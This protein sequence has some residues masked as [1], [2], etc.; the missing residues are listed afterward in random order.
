MKLNKQWIKE[1]GKQVNEDK[2]FKVI[3]NF[4][5][6]PFRNPYPVF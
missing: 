5:F 2:V 4:N 1:W 6:F 3:G